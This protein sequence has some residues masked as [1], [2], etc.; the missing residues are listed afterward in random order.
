[1]GRRH[2][3]LLDGDVHVTLAVEQV[4]GGL[5][6]VAAGDDH[7]RGP[8]PS[9]HL[10]QFVTRPGTWSLGAAR[11]GL[12]LGQIRRHDGREREQPVDE[13]LDGIVLKEP[14]AAGRDHDRIDYEGHGMVGEEL[15]H[16]FDHRTREQHPRLGGIDP[17]VV[18]DCLELLADELRRHLV[19]AGDAGRVLR[20]QRDDRAHPVRAGGREGLQVGLDPGAAA[21]IG[22]RN[23]QNSRNQENSLR[24][25]EPDQVRRV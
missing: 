11:K 18:P 3:V 10:C 23:R 6:A 4:V 1:V 20:G 17:D 21:G 8:E 5:A 15:R 9:Q 25:Y 12:C 14:G 13:R 22:A 19:D 7:R 2:L 24:R 16:R